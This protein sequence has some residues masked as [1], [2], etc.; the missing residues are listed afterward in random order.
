[1]IDNDFSQIPVTLNNKLHGMI[2]AEDLVHTFISTNTRT[3]RGDRVGFKESRF[4]GQIKGIMDSQPY[5]INE[6]TDLYQIINNVKRLDKNAAIL[7]NNDLEV[8]GIITKRDVVSLILRAEKPKELPI[9]I[10]GL[11]DEDFFER[12]VAEKKIRRVVF[13]NL[14]IHPDISEVRIRIKKQRTRGERSYYRINAKAISPNN[15]FNASHEG[16]G[17]METF[18][19]LCEILDKS[20]KRAKKIPQKGARRGRRRPN[21]HLKL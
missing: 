21:P 5:S 9:S 13:R 14:R 17:L 6:E 4:D 10:Q 16:W 19:G 11:L 8:R 3:T 7:V 2:T 18:D 12:A 20:L 1:M 15:Q